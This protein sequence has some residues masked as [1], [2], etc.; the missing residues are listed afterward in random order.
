MC[1]PDVS[2][3][4]C[5]SGTHR[6]GNVCL[7]DGPGVTCGTGTHLDGAVCVLDGPGL[8][9][10]P[11]THAEDNRCVL[12]TTPVT[13]GDGTHQDGDQCRPDV[14][15]G[16]G[17]HQ[18]GDHCAPDVTCGEGTHKDGV[19]CVPDAAPLSCGAGTHQDGNQCVPDGPLLTCGPG[20]H[21]EGLVCVPDGP[22]V[23]CGSGTHLEGSVCVPDGP[24]VTCG[25]GTHR[26][27]NVCLPDAAPVICGPG[28]HQSDNQCLPDVICGPGT[29]ADG[30]TCVPIDHA[31]YELRVFS[32]AFEADGHTKVP[33]L[34]VGTLADGSPATD[35]VVLTT[36]RASAGSFVDAHPTLGALGT[37]ALFSPCNATAAGCAGA[38]RISLALASDPGTEVAHLDVALVAPTAVASPAPCLVAD[39]AMFF[40]GND[41]IFNGTMLVTAGVFTNIFQTNSR[42][43]TLRVTPSDPSQGSQWFLDFETTQLGT[44]MVPGVYENAMRWPFETEGHPG[45]SI[46]GNGRGCNIVTGRFQVHFF[47]LQPD[48]HTIKRALLTFEQHCEG[49]PLLLSGCIHVE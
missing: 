42:T 22:I 33:V 8:T 19:V 13:C 5:G 23:T 28:T 35:A 32:S 48:N 27:G 39:Q 21:R 29:H 38:L 4:T 47:E 16:D 43:L 10:G 26:D 30:N 18:D 15:C 3:L 9:C 45:L 41:F 2:Q 46:D 44:D 20:T 34:L 37:L 14:T 1:L 31:T 12:D 6:D 24:G 40:D 36:D 49:G 7:P 25:P 17:T 11:G